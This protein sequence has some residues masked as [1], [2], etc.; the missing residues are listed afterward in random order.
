M[1]D[2]NLVLEKE[3]LMKII[4]ILIATLALP[5]MALGQDQSQADQGK[6]KEQQEEQAPPKKK[7]ARAPQE[8]NKAPAK[9]ETNA[10]MHQRARTEGHAKG[11]MQTEGHAKGAMPTETGTRSSKTHTK[12]NKEQFRSSHTEVFQLGRHPKNFFVQRYG[13]NHFRLIGNTYFV[14]VDGCWVSVD[15]AGFTFVQRVICDGDPDYIVVY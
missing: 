11:A 10:N 13:A 3:H 12:V 2:T 14:F 7:K 6:K 5:L 9:A 8:A 15:V 4:S 1:Q